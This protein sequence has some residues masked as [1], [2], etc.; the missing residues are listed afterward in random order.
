MDNFSLKSEKICNSNLPSDHDDTQLRLQA[1]VGS[2]ELD[3]AEDYA[4]GQ[5]ML[6]LQGHSA[7]AARAHVP[8]VPR[9]QDDPE[10]GAYAEVPL[11]FVPEDPEDGR[12][13][14]TPA[15]L[16]VIVPNLCVPVPDGDCA[17]LPRALAPARV[18]T[19]HIRPVSVPDHS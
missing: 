17:P 1:Q 6:V 3:D 15:P 8:A 13:A 9:P 16:F 7:A 2:L 4:P 11:G 12:T 5:L 18:C 14:K 10:P 19:G